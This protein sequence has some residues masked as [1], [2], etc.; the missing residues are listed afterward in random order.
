VTTLSTGTPSFHHDFAD[1]TANVLQPRAIATS[2]PLFVSQNRPSA[3]KILAWLERHGCKLWIQHLPRGRRRKNRAVVEYLDRA[4]EVRAV[5]GIDIAHAVRRAQLR[6][7]AAQ[8]EPAG[9][10]S[11]DGAGA[12]LASAGVNGGHPGGTSQ[13]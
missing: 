13:L 5:G 2:E 10:P 7:E 11:A 3:V 9:K 8:A 6:L 12:S 4:G 1:G